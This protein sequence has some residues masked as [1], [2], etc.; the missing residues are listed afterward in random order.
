[1]ECRAQGR[2]GCLGGGSV[3]W[4]GTLDEEKM[5]FNQTYTDTYDYGSFYAA[6]SGAGLSNSGRR[7][8]FGWINEVVC[9]IGNIYCA[10]HSPLPIILSLLSLA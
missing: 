7:L 5:Q 10:Q 2:H 3:Y 4:T 9:A 6:K 1:M 8:I